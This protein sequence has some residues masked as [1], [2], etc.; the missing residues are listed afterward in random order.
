MA[1][2]ILY[3][4]ADGKWIIDPPNGI[5]YSGEVIYTKG[6]EKI[7]ASGA[8]DAC[9][10]VLFF[11]K[12]NE[13]AAIAHIQL[14]NTEQY[15]DLLSPI[16]AKKFNP[17]TTTVYL[18]GD[19]PSHEYENWNDEIESYIVKMGFTVKRIVQGNGKDIIINPGADDLVIKDS[20]NRLLI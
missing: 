9:R 17:G 8:E 2:S 15:K 4:Y 14:M 1:K 5:A 10:L 6:D 16:R 19:E 12:Q 7:E 18:C 20:N 11:D 3:K 13:K